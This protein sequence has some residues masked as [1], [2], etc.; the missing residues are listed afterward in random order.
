M[1][2]ATLVVA[3]LDRLSRDVEFLAW[4]RKSKVKFVCADMPR[5]TD[6]TIGLLAEVAQHERQTISLRVKEALAE[7][8]KRG[9]KFGPPKGRFG[10]WKAGS[11][12]LQQ[13]LER[14]HY[15]A[16]Q[17]LTRKADTFAQRLA[18]TLKK[19]QEPTLKKKRGLTQAEMAERLNE[20]GIKTPR[21]LKGR[22]TQGRVSR[23]L[24]RL[25]PED[26]EDS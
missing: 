16:S 7:A 20:R 14:A 24:S 3:K 4:L 12:E 19:M 15:Q 13:M 9:T 8:K 25:Q 1:T 11:P 5:V 2:D 6:F 21:G 26:R 17:A 18:P 23:V 22:W 10:K